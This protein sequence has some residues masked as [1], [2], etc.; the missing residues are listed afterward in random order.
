MFRWPEL[1]AVCP[2]PTETTALANNPLE[3][4]S[5]PETDGNTF[6]CLKESNLS[7][8][9]VLLSNMADAVTSLTCTG[10]QDNSILGALSDD[11]RCFGQSLQVHATDYSRVITY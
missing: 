9:S 6:K 1:H 2:F 7:F 8:V 10:R 5:E 11:F 3:I 4:H